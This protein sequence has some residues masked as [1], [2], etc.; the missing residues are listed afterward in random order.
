MAALFD[1]LRMIDAARYAGCSTAT[2][3]RA[4]DRGELDGVVV[5]GVGRLVRRESVDAWAARRAE[6]MAA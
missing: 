4:F 1:L 5:P 6:R 3:R 2:V